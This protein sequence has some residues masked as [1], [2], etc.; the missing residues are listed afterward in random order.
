MLQANSP[1]LK[2]DKID[3]AIK[4][5]ISPLT[6]VYECLSINKTDLITDGAIRVFRRKC[7]NNRGLGMYLSAVLTDYV[8][9]H[10]IEDIKKIENLLN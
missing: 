5:V 4:K 2:S 9:V 10:T 6:N 8:D 7:L 1:Q 3:E